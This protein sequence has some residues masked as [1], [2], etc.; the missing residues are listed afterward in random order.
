M[1]ITTAPSEGDRLH[2]ACQQLP[3]LTANGRAVGAT[4]CYNLETFCQSI[5]EH[6]TI[7]VVVF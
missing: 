4:L 2:P 3:L 7:F 6:D 5:L 1:L